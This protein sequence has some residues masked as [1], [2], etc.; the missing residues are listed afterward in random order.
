[1]IYAERMGDQA[2][3]EDYIAERGVFLSLAEFLPYRAA[4]W[5]AV[6]RFNKLADA[7]LRQ[8]GQSE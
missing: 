1:M 7:A 5:E 4:G 3:G 6:E 2:A 8:E